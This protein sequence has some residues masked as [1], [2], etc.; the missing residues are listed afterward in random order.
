MS[1]LPK[2]LKFDTG[3]GLSQLFKVLISLQGGRSQ[4]ENLLLQGLSFQVFWNK[5]PCS[6][7]DTDKCPTLLMAGKWRKTEEIERERY[8][9]N[10]RQGRILSIEIRPAC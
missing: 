1:L 5:K 3:V 6:S 10:N 2:V 9:F 7:S 8:V 4:E